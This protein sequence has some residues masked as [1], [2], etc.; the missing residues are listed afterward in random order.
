MGHNIKR[1]TFEDYGP[2]SE[3]YLC[4]TVGT[5]KEAKN[6]V[7]DL[8]RGNLYTISV[9]DKLAGFVVL[10]AGETGTLTVRDLTISHEFHGLALGRRLLDF[11]EQYAAERGYK[12][13]RAKA[14]RS[15]PTATWLYRRFGYRLA[16][17]ADWGAVHEKSLQIADDGVLAC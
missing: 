13:L 3:L 10:E 1:A 16:E 9:N 5:A 17:A 15:T 7:Q 11:A 12:R 6:L 4:E 8:W 2:V 14:E